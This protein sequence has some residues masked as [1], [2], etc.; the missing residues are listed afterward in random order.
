VSPSAGR[1][2]IRARL[3]KL[4]RQMNDKIKAGTKKNGKYTRWN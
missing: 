3:M 2:T 4:N 1:V